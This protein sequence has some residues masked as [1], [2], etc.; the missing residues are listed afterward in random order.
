MKFSSKNPNKRV[1]EQSGDGPLEKYR[2]VLVPEEAVKVKSTHRGYWAM[3]HALAT[4]EQTKQGILFF[5]P[6]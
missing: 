1:L 2:K 3:I 6:K 4:H 5:F